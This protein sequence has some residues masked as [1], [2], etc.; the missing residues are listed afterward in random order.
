MN[1]KKRDPSARFLKQ[2]KPQAPPHEKVVHFTKPELQEEPDG[3]SE[4]IE[5]I[6]KKVRHAMELLE[7][8]RQV[9]AFNLLKRIVE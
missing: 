2:S 4:A 8:G 6:K 9:A 1:R 5:D 7:Q 3:E